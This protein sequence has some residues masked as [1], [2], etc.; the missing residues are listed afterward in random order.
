MQLDEISTIQK[1]LLL[2]ALIGLVGLFM[3]VSNPLVISAWRAPVT[4]NS[5]ITANAGFISGFAGPQTGRGLAGDGLAPFGNPLQNVRT[6]M[7]QGYGVGSHAPA[8]T[9]GGVDLAIDG[10]GNGEADP[11]GTDGAPVF[12]M[13]DGVASVRPNTWPAGNYLSIENESYKV[14]YAHLSNYA[15]QDGETVKRGQLIGYV[16]A[17][18]MA[19][20]PHLH[21]E[22][23]QHGQNVNP[24]DFGALEP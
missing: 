1:A 10:D 4:K 6:V 19:N 24:L 21:Y 7:T 11:Q 23:W 13:I 16:G 9:W 22:V 3:Q 20:G 8:E 5:A 12:A 18:G 14:A 2:L 17:T 15:I